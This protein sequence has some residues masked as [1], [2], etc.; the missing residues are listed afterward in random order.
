[1]R[2]KGI[3]RWKLSLNAGKSH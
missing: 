3:C 1:M 2:F